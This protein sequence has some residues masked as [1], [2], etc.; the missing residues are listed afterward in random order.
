MTENGVAWLYVDSAMQEKWNLTREDAGES[1]GFMSG[2]KGSICWLA[3][4]IPPASTEKN[5]QAHPVEA[6]H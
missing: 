4:N 5:V 6:A 2:I 1:V 3:N